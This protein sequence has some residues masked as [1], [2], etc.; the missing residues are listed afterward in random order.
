M[1]YGTFR[2]STKSFEPPAP[3]VA[4][5]ER[6]DVVVVSVIE[7]N[8]QRVSVKVADLSDR[9]LGGQSAMPLPIGAEASVTLPRIGTVPVQ[10]RWAL[11]TRFGARFIHRIPLDDLF[12]APA[13]PPSA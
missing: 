8:G 6:T 3:T 1:R 5:S 2:K 4:R 13:E 9:G 10:I 7:L 12:A 11:G